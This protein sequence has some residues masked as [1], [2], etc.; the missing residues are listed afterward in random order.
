MQH[1][2]QDTGELLYILAEA[3]HRGEAARI[4]AQDLG[5]LRAQAGCRPNAEG[6]FVF[7]LRPPVVRAGAWVERGV[8]FGLL[9]CLAPVGL[10]LVLLVGLW[11]GWPPIFRQVRYGL[12]G[13]KFWLYKLRTMRRGAEQ[14]LAE[15]QAA[16][17]TPERPFKL[18]SDPRVT[19]LG[20]F[21][22]AHFLDELPQLYNVLRGEMRFV[23]PRPLPASDQ[24]L[25]TQ[26]AH[27]LRLRG[28]PGMTGLWQTMGRHRF[29]FDQMCILD[30][31]YLCNRT[32][33]WDLKL[34]L[35][36]L[37]MIV[38]R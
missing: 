30:Y 3:A 8:A 12:Q 17:S 26:A 1:R 7:K 18:A 38:R 2:A 20:R 34:L 28:V 14:E 25:Y 32:W 23:G 21:L 13:Q 11:D 27:A 5:F 6:Y 4:A 31:Y 36:T 29:T 24:H 22:R 10:F 16:V 15:L 9:L 37:K 33:W 19:P 35:R